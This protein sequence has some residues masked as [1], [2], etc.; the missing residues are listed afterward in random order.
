MAKLYAL[1]HNR[2]QLEVEYDQA[3]VFWNRHA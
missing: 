2:T 3:P 1:E